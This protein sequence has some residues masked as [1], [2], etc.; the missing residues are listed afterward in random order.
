MKKTVLGL[1]LV[2]MLGLVGCG[3]SQQ[4]DTQAAPADQTGG[5]TVNVDDQGLN[6]QSGDTSVNVNPEGGV[7]VETGQ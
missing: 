3:G 7:S 1:V 4:A 5:T 6:V 2:C